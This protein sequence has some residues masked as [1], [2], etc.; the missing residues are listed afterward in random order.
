VGKGLRIA[1]HI[2]RLRFFADEMTQL[3]LAERA[4]CS[5]QTIHA[6]ESGKYTPSLELAF[7][8]AQAFSVPITEVFECEP[9]ESEAEA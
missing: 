7:R 4:G 5:R 8:I 1:N 6:L 9:D 2:R 3:D